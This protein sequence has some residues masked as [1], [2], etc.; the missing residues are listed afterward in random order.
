MSL[1]RFDVSGGARCRSCSEIV[2]IFLQEIDGMNASEPVCRVCFERAQ[3]TG[4]VA[5]PAKTQRQKK[6]RRR[7]PD[8]ILR[9]KELN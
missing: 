3:L 7:P 9:P 6:W 5:D 2:R 8:E 1:T 4:L